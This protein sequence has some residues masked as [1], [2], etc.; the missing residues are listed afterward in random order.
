MMKQVF[1]LALSAVILGLSLA[2]IQPARP[3]QV[4][5]ND[6]VCVGL[7]NPFVTEDSNIQPARKCRFCLSW[8]QY[9]FFVSQSLTILLLSLLI[10]SLEL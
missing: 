6:N 8:C 10:L 3:V 4:A 9:G 1:T 5:T 2:W 7:D